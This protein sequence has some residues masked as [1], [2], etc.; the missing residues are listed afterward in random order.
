MKNIGMFYGQRSSAIEAFR[1]HSQTANNLAR[2]YRTVNVNPK[3]MTIIYDN[4]IR[5][6]YYGFEKDGDAQSRVAGINFQAI[7]SENLYHADKQYVLTR[8]RPSLF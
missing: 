2:D 8:F 7:F 6:M 3:E 4:E 5:Y 1:K